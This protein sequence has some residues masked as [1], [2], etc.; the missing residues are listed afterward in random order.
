MAASIG[1]LL[2]ELVTTVSKT[3]AGWLPEREPVSAQ[4]GASDSS[5]RWWPRQ[6]GRRAPTRASKARGRARLRTEHVIGRLGRVAGREWSTLGRWCAPA[7]RSP[8][9]CWGWRTAGASRSRR[10]ARRKG[11]NATTACRVGGRRELVGAMSRTG[12]R[13]QAH[14]ARSALILVGASTARS[15]A[16]QATSRQRRPLHGR[17]TTSK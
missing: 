9:R 16:N 6:S 14:Q 2:V 11:R 3:L 8:W 12:S 17:A 4:R 5:W 1:R 13:K 15:S 10:A 7:E